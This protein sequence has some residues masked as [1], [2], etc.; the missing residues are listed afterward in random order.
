MDQRA[1]LHE[2]NLE[3]LVL[4]QPPGRDFSMYVTPR[5]RQHYEELPF[6]PF[7]A[8]LVGKQ[9]VHTRLFIDVGA[10]YGFYSLLAGKRDPTLEVIA[11]EP[12]PETCRVLE[13][14]VALNGLRN[15][16]IHQVAVSDRDGSMP[17]NVSLSSDSCGFYPNPQAMPLRQVEVMTRLLDTVLA[18]HPPCDTLI[19]IDTEGHELAVLK[20]AAA[21]IARFP[22]VRFLVEFNPLMQG[23]AG[24]DQ[25][26]LLAAIH[27][28]GYTASF[29]DETSG[30]VTA[31]ENQ[32]QLAELAHARGYGNLYC[33]RRPPL[34]PSS[35]N[36]TGKSLRFVIESPR[37]W[38]LDQRN[39]TIQ[40]WCFGENGLVVEELRARRG[41]HTWHA[42]YGL[43]REDVGRAFAHDPE[44]SVSGFE[45]KVK[46]PI[47]PGWLRLEAKD[48]HGRWHP[49]TSRLVSRWRHLVHRERWPASPAVQQ[50][51]LARAL[52]RI[53]NGLRFES[54]V[55]AIS[56][57]DYRIAVGGTQ[58][59]LQQE[60]ALLAARGISYLEIHPAP[61]Q[62][63]FTSD[64]RDFRMG[65]YVDSQYLGSFTVAQMR[66]VLA[67]I[68]QRPGRI[69][70]VH[71]HH[72]MGFNLQ[73]V[74]DL[75]ADLPAPKTVFIH[76]FY[77]VCRQWN[78][79]KNDSQYC[80]G[81]P[82]ESQACREC[83]YGKDRVGHFASYRAFFEKWNPGFVAPSE[84]AR[85]IWAASF[86]HLANKVRIVPHLVRR[87]G[88]T[89]RLPRSATEK[90]RIAYIGYQHLNKGWEEWNK[91]VGF[92]SPDFYE[93]YVLG[94]CSD[95]LPN[96]HY[97]PVSFIED[98]ADAM[99]KAL[100]RERIDLA[101][102]WS[103]VPETYSFTVF[104]AMA[105]GCFVLTNPGSGNIAAQ[106]KQSSRGR[107]A[108]NLDDLVAFLKDNSSV[109]K[110]LEQF[111]AQ[112]PPFEL[113]PNSE[114]TDE[115]AERSG[116]TI[117]PA[118]SPADAC[119]GEPGVITRP[120]AGS[121]NLEQAEPLDLVFFTSVTGNYLPKAAV[122][123]NSLRTHRP[124]AAFYIILCDTPPDGLEAFAGAFDRVFL[125]K[126]LQLPVANRDQWIFKHSVVELCT[127]VKGPFLCQLLEELHANKVVYFDPDIVVMDD[128]RGLEQLLESHNIILTP[129]LVDP[130]SSPIAIL[131]NEV[132]SLKH[133]A[134]NL[135]FIAVRNGPG[136]RRFA[137]WWSDRLTQFCYD[138]IPNGLFTDQRWMDLAPGFFPDLHIL[139]DRTYNVATWNLSQRRVEQRADGRL[140]IGGEPV[141][142]F[143]FSGFDSGA[144]WEMLKRYGQHSPA[145]F[146]LRDW[147]IQELGRTGQT[148]YGALKWGYDSYSN[149]R[150]ILN[151]HRRLYRNRPDLM[152]AYPTP[153]IVNNGQDSFYRWC[154]RHFKGDLASQQRLPLL[155]RWERS[156]R[157]RVPFLSP[158]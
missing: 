42:R 32:G 56:H 62:P 85:D 59:L 79:L 33:R 129:H 36:G 127:A 6:E 69:R 118:P 128:L 139:R 57:S 126:D 125:L 84:V 60:E 124:K 116:K 45:V 153:A 147:Y 95:F 77:T 133:G 105:A 131:E 13:R 141:K 135:G 117:A 53:L 48:Q 114:L 112:H 74:N 14:N 96:V 54:C 21:T 140:C 102:L 3:S 122:L 37:R 8:D 31:V 81:P 41:R 111:R 46:V 107:I 29:L 87:E 151:G 17:F 98:G 104:E 71:L 156:I 20:G 108:S 44:A 89:A 66:Q 35:R 154:A 83:R 63:V 24:Y 91:L 22:D 50:K 97:V 109:G 150:P 113:V 23:A 157:K 110:Q 144:Q 155:K 5:Y 2:Y 58:K 18:G 138:D 38:K 34:P 93:C 27:G 106:V 142:F 143:H 132:C 40:G 146:A 130:E 52:P 137:R 65:F 86:P 149:G 10:H 61:E 82:V 28:M 55:L 16:A 67:A 9:L 51:N 43:P 152:Q 30:Q 1:F 101:F 73:L 4:V 119:A 80:G 47:F 145:L 49:M 39:L 88:A 148:K 136:G 68:Q 76:D 100:H 158:R 103:L 120:S 25:S 19:K 134:F 11:F 70:T 99:K 75:L 78:L 94:N 121:G 115:I 123:A 90:I 92:L 15:V 64:Y 7:S 12:T 26:A 72:L